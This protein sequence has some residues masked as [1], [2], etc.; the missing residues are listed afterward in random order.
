MP[1]IRYTGPGHRLRLR[2]G[3]FLPRGETAEVDDQEAEELA[4][5][6]HINVTLVEP[7]PEPAPAKAKKTPPPSGSKE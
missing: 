7:E 1:K 5:N 2:S 3:D 6:P 4:T